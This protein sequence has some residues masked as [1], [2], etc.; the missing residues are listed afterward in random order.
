M[1]STCSTA[2]SATSIKHPLSQRYELIR[3][4]FDYRPEPVSDTDLPST[5]AVC[6]EDQRTCLDDTNSP[7]ACFPCDVH[8]YLSDGV[9][10]R[11][12]FCT[13]FYQFT[14]HFFHIKL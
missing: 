4:M 14:V 8:Q 7:T 5:F 2:V 1:S 13:D 11:A 10:G 3:S 9:S 12:V 6:V